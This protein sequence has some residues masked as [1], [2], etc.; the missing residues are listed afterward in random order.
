MD[1]LVRDLLDPGNYPDPRPS[2]VKLATT[3]ASWVFLTDTDAWK[4]KRPVDY[5]FLD[6]TT[7]EKRRL[8]CEAEL[9][10]NRRLAPDVYLGV[11]P[12]RRDARGHSFSRGGEIVDHAVRM[13]RLDDDDSAA[14]WIRDGRPL[15]PELAGLA[16]RLADFHRSH[17]GKAELGSPEALAVSV[18]ENFAQLEPRLGQG[19]DEATFRGVRAWQERFLRDRADLLRGRVARG[20]ISEGHGD[21]RLDHWYVGGSLLIDCI[22]FNERFRHMDGAA[23]LAFLAMDLEVHGH[24]EMASWLL[25]RY[26]ERRDDPGLYRVIDFYLSYRAWVRGKVALFQ[27]SDPGRAGAKRREAATHFALAESYT[28]PPDRPRPVI[29]VGGLIGSGKSTLAE[30]IAYSLALPLVSS[31]RLRK[32]ASAVA[33]AYD[34]ASRRAVYDELFRRAEPVLESARGVVLDASFWKQE[35]RFAARDLAARHGRPFLFVETE[36][37]EATIRSR[38]RARSGGDSDAREDLLERFTSWYEPVAELER[39][40]VRTTGDLRAPVRG[41]AGR[42]GLPVH[43]GSYWWPGRPAS[44]S[45]TPG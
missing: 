42:L 14:A 16:S 4:L 2:A 6:F 22:E 35:L 38:L 21:L 9:V 20:F 19:V 29:A 27:A 23:D 45:Q 18:E 32:L 10:L 37:D 17:P 1:A 33:P 8:D 31:D 12:V 30:A 25:S 41:I 11:V 13:R 34:E 3:H 36:C 44:T 5:G 43:D 24:P 39:L 15:G 28:R 40:G 26:A 7:P